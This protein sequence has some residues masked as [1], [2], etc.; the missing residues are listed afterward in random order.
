MVT[1]FLWVGAALLGCPV[2]DHTAFSF[3]MDNDTFSTPST[4]RDYT[5]GVLFEWSGGWVRRGFLPHV[6][7]GIDHVAGLGGLSSFSPALD[8][9]SFQFG[10]SAFTPKKEDLGRTDPIYD[11]RPYANLLYVLVRRARVKGPE[12]GPQTAIVTDFTLGALGLNVGKAVQT[13][14]HKAKD[15]AIPGGWGHQIASGGEP[16]LRYR[17]S[18]RHRFV[19]KNVLGRTK[20]DVSGS[21]DASLGFYTNASLGGRIRFGRIATP[22]YA[23]ERAPIVPYRASPFGSEA[24]P[25]CPGKAHRPF[26]A[27]VWASGGGTVWAYNE[28][29]QGGFRHSDVTLGY[30]K[31][32]AP[33][34]PFIADLQVGGTIRLLPFMGFAYAYSMHTPLFGG[35]KSRD[36]HWGGFTLTF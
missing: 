7:K 19:E 3:Y 5:M 15:D 31:D 35:P 13:A 6:I 24:Q 1:G 33:L 8:S 23:Q 14:I 22:W 9:Y 4:D 11:D 25:A 2:A 18:L 36:H 10:D 12:G 34:K 28:L 29:L 16:T 17:V 32:P 30:G 27:Y 26:E 20:V 21:A